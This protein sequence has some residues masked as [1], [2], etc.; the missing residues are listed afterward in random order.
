MPAL[1]NPT[2]IRALS[3]KTLGALSLAS[4]ASRLEDGDARDALSKGAEQLLEA[5]L[6]E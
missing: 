2:R 1:R 3:A 5:G 6:A 4:V